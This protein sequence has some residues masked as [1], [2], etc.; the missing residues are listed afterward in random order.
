[1]KSKMSLFFI[2]LSGYLSSLVVY[3]TWYYTIPY[4]TL[5]KITDTP[6]ITTVITGITALY[7]FLYAFILSIRFFQTPRKSF[8]LISIITVLTFFLIPSVYYARYHFGIGIEKKHPEKYRGKEIE[9]RLDNPITIINIANKTITDLQ[10]K[11]ECERKENDKLRK[12]LEEIIRKTKFLEEEEKTNGDAV[13]PTKSKKDVSKIKA[14]AADTDSYTKD[15]EIIFK[16][17]IMSSSTHLSKDC[18]Q[19]KGLKNLWEYKDGD[20]YKYTVGN[21]KDFKSASVL[22][23]EFRRKGFPGAFVVAFRNGIRIPMKKA[24]DTYKMHVHQNK[25]SL[26]LTDLTDVGN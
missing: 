4:Y 25:G 1:M 20:L 7:L 13:N 26:F 2:L 21:Q 24:M 11:L 3:L 6:N 17:Q 8:L 14:Q 23:L 5:N 19:F 16:V 18:S 12:R 10:A 22:Q 9:T 15:Q